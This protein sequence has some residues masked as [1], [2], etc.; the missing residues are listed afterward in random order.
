MDALALEAMQRLEV[1]RENPQRTRLV[2][3]EESA[4]LVRDVWSHRLIRHELS[5]TLA[6]SMNPR[7][8]ST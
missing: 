6:K 1:L 4:L 3:L 8:T 5:L 2:A 7:S